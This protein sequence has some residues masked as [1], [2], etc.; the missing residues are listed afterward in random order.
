[1]SSRAMQE[2]VANLHDLTLS[3]D[4]GARALFSFDEN[5]IGF[6]GH[7][8]TQKVLP[9]VC[10]VQCALAT[11]GRASGVLPELVGVINAKFK[12]VVVPG[13]VIQ[14]TCSAPVQKKGALVLIATIMKAEEVVSKLSLSISV[15]KA[16]DN[17]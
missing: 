3:D 11:H 15:N 5:F 16:Q 2:I 1:M 10:L 14:C 13:D 7:F 9:G 8:P 6:Q 12:S 4:G 17:S